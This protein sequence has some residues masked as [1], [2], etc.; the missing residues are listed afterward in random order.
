VNFD[1]DGGFDQ[2]KLISTNYSFEIDDLAY[3][4]DYEVP[5]PMTAMLLGAGL[6]ALGASRRRRA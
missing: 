4:R 5:A 1:V 2:V 3:G 6:L